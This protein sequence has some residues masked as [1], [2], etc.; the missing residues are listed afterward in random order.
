[1]SDRPCWQSNDHPDQFLFRVGSHP[2]LP[3]SI[4]RKLRW[5]LLRQALLTFNAD[6]YVSNDAQ[7]REILTV[8]QVA[9]MLL[10]DKETVAE[11]LK[12]GEL[13]GLKFG[14]SWIIPATS[15]YQRLNDLA[16]EQSNAR[17]QACHKAESAPDQQHQQ[18]TK[19]KL[20]RP[21]FHSS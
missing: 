2:D 15:F 19:R 1:M 7:M 8:E 20:G 21:R 10:C 18:P 13:P 3:G 5:G 12:S 4:A 6:I 9:E 17:R 16:V 11:Y 14:R